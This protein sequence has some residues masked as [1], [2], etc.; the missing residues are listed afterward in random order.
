M[1]PRKSP[2]KPNQGIT[3]PTEEPPRLCQLKKSLL[4]RFFS[5][6]ILYF[7]QCNCE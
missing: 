4:L 1:E 7:K 3:E 6:C 2:P 5:L